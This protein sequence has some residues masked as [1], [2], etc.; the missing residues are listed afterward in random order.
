MGEGELLTQKN[1]NCGKLDP[2]LEGLLGIGEKGFERSYP[3]EVIT[4]NE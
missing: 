3:V 4:L 2:T 1:P